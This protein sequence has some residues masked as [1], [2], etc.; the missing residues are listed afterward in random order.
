MGGSLFRA[1]LFAL[2]LVSAACAKNTVTAENLVRPELIE[3]PSGSFVFGSTDAE[4]EHAYQLDERAYGHSRTRTSGWYNTEPALQT[5]FLDSYHISK[6]L[7]TNDQYRKF[8]Q[9]TGHPPPQV[10]EKTWQ[11]Y[12]L[13]HPYTRTRRHQWRGQDYPPGRARHPVVLISYYDAQAYANWLSNVTGDKWRLPTER[14]WVKAARGRDGRR[15][16]WGDEFDSGKLNS[17]DAGPFDTVVVGSLSAPSP[18]G[19]LDSAGQ[20]FEW[21]RSPATALR[22]WVKGGSWDDKG[23]G[24]CRPAA[25]HSRP[26]KLKHILIGFRLVKE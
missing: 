4:R 16:P 5:L 24:V 2:V 23:C 9:A 22:G 20:V 25:R 26:K 19:M 14:E 17:H 3:V 1:S 7:I 8:L 11:T 10:D 18:F 13:I 21:M 6:N 12:G 15:F